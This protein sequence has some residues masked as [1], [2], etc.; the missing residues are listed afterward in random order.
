MADRDS[1]I[2][3]LLKQYLPPAD[4]QPSHV[5][6]DAYRPWPRLP[7]MSDTRQSFRNLNPRPMPEF[8]EKIASDISPTMGAYGTANLL[9]DTY[10]KGR[11]GN[12]SEVAD[13]APLA[14]GALFGF[15]RRGK[16]MVS[17]PVAEWPAGAA[18]KVGEKVY[19]GVTHF[20]ALQKS[21]PGALERGLFAEDLMDAFKAHHGTDTFGADGFVTNLGRYVDRDEAAKLAQAK[22]GTNIG[23]HWGLDAVAYERALAR[24]EGRRTKDEA[25]PP[26]VPGLNWL[27]NWIARGGSS[28]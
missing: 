3:D 28:E 18:I 6:E 16:P 8:Q 2:A 21:V 20:D 23:K 26:P 11:E 7:P 12:W 22:L 5:L 27:R 15:G 24:H 25:V 4:T 17:S 13:Q 9:A 14:A 19:S 1:A 10:D